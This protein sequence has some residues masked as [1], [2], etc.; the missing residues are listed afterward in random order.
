MVCRGVF[1]LVNLEVALLI[2]ECQQVNWMLHTTCAVCLAGKP[3]STGTSMTGFLRSAGAVGPKNKGLQSGVQ[4]VVMA[5]VVAG[6]G[7]WV[8]PRLLVY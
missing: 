2:W 1:V 6:T 4:R 5:R 3:R 7:S 8:N